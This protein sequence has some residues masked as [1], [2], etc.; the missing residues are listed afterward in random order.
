MLL[1]LALSIQLR[2][3]HFILRQDFLDCSALMQI[4]ECCVELIDKFLVRK[5][6]LEPD[7]IFQA[8]FSARISDIL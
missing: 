3:V 2:G 6:L 4:A 8:L 7:L 5:L 1:C